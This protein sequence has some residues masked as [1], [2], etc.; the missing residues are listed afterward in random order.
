MCKVEKTKGEE[1]I[2][3]LPLG[4]LWSRGCDYDMGEA[5]PRLITPKKNN[6]EVLMWG[7]LPYIMPDDVEKLLKDLPDKN[8]PGRTFGQQPTA[9]AARVARTI[10]TKEVRE[11]LKYLQGEVDPKTL[12]NMINGACSLIIEIL[13]IKF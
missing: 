12:K 1:N 7:V 9:N 2:D 11:S 4:W 6:I 13:S 5:G 10:S 8:V 3:L